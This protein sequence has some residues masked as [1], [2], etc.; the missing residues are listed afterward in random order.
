MRKL[1]DMIK[2]KWIK[3][4]ISTVAIVA[5][6]LVV[7]WLINFL[8]M[9][10]D[11]SP[12]DFTKEKLYTLSDESKE[13]IKKVEQNVT[14]YFFGYDENSTVMT[15]A[16][17]Y[18]DLN[19][20]ITVQSIDTSERPDLATQYGVNTNSQLVAVQS[21]QRYKIIDSSEMYTY[22]STNS[23]TIDITEQK[24]TNAILDVT[25]S[26][27]PQVYFLTGHGEYGI[28]QSS[29]MAMFATYIEND[30]NDVNTLDLLTADMPETCDILIIASPAKDFTDLETEKIQNYINGGGNIMWLQDPYL[31]STN[32][33]D[34]KELV[35]VNKI[36]SQYGISFS[37]GVV[38]EQA[39]S[40][41]IAGSPDLI[42][43]Q[44]TY[45]D[46]VKDLYTDGTVV[47]LDSGKINTVSDEELEKLGVTASPFLKSTDQAFYR[48]NINSDITTKLATDEEG[49]FVLAEILTKKI[50]DEKES[51]LVAY[52]NALFATNYQIQLSNAIGTPISI[53]QNKDIVLNTISFLANREDAIRIRKD[54]GIVTFDAATETQN[55]IVIF[56]IFAIPVI[57]IIAGIVVTIMRKR[58]K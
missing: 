15:L 52:S 14:L 21:S 42:I 44:M 28:G 11:V 31:F 22:D 36:L 33:T 55:R 8:F 9:K 10:L 4:T 16:K 39:E 12:L 58:K 19:D 1:I 37:N 5:V 2:K 20:K 48:E 32:I 6:L 34:G 56:I 54:T 49:P 13:Q 40:N 25:I 57:I 53:R 7:F 29:E 47:L 18:K 51:K 24:L 3:D 50:D 35:N 26:K 30:V 45:N 38:C 41:M 17:K 23:Q 43:P 27:K 46:I